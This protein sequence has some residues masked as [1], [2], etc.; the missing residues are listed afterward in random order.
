MKMQINFVIYSKTKKIYISKKWI[1]L[2]K[3]LVFLILM[4]K[5]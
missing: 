5:E 1:K 3:N 2:E 4:M